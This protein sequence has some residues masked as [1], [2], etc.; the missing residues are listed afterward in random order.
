MGIE[1]LRIKLG[2]IELKTPIIMASGT[3]GYGLEKINFIDYKKIGAITTKTI[4]YYPWE[5][6]PQP[7]IYE[8]YSGMINSIGLQNPGVFYFIKNI[9]PKIRKKFN[10][11]FVSISGRTENEFIQ[12]IKIMNKE[13]IDALELNLSCPNFEKEQKMISQSSD[14]TYKIV[15]KIKNETSIPLIAKLSPNVTNIKEIA[16]AAE[17]AGIDMISVINTVK[18]LCVDLK[19]MKIIDGGLSGGCIKPI[20]LKCVYDIYKVVKIPIIGIGGIIKGT[21]AIEYFLVG[22]SA[23]GIGSGLFTNSQIIDEV[24]KSLINFLNKTKSKNLKEITGLLNE[25]KGKNR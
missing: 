16:I 4:T 18:G 6:N 9:L 7:R 19:K 23:I 12:L 24:I 1:K 10:K 13:K 21:D 15:K 11:I 5:G 2:H 20:G 22:A 14:L 17:E 25:K 3:F 8:T